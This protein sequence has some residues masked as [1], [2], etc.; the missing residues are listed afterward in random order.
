[1]EKY[2]DKDDVF[3]IV[4]EQGEK[5]GESKTYT[6]VH[7]K[8]LLHITAHVWLLNSKGQILLQ[9][10]S[11]QVRV[12]PGYW[13][14]SASGHVLAGQ[15]SLEG[16]QTETEEELGV[17]L[18][19][20]DFKYLFT[21]EEQ[22]I[23]NNGSHIEHALNDVYIVNHDAPLEEFKLPPDEVEEVRWLDKEEFEK[24]ISGKGEKMCLHLE[25]YKKILEYLE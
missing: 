2:K 23:L 3:D 22:Y 6:E 4:N 8:G 1:M 25:E 9:K 20:S 17:T 14:N 16:A 5:T 24:W 15:S 12:Y 10:R 13:D 21:I 19:L 11:K 7:E 18:L